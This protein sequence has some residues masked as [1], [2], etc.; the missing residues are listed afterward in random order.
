MKGGASSTAL[1]GIDP[2]TFDVLDPGTPYSRYVTV[3]DDTTAI[4]VDLPASWH[5]D[6]RLRT[7]ENNDLP[8]VN[9]A[10]DLDAYLANESTP[11][12]RFSAYRGPL[13]AKG[14]AWALDHLAEIDGIS[15]CTGKPERVAFEDGGYR[16][17]AVV[18][19]GCGVDGQ[20]VN[21]HIVASDRQGTGAL[22]VIQVQLKTQ[23]DVEALAKVISSFKVPTDG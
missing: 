21:V 8:S 15:S 23:A 22:A 2:A 10:T 13:R 19:T 4:S 1:G 3:E 16:G 17:S 11:G 5:T 20:L 7:L 6:G 12:M 18:T 9:A 14:E